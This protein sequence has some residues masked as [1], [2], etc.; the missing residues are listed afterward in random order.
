MSKTVVTAPYAPQVTGQSPVIRWITRHTLAAFFLLTFG[1]SWLLG[2]PL[3]LSSWQVVPV[4]L[5]R[6]PAVLIQQ[7]AAWGP[8]LTA[9]VL[10]GLIS[11]KAG[12]RAFPRRLVRWRVGV[13]WYLFV[14]CSYGLIILTAL[15]VN[16]LLGGALPAGV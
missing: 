7:L 16:A 6:V 14:F 15:G 2:L 12:L 11:G 13:Q 5:A 3:V 8:T 4:H 1:Y 9:L 10:T